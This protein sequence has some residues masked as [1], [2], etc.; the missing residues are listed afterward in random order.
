MSK[1]HLAIVIRT[2]V[3]A[4]LSIGWG[5]LGMCG[6]ERGV[7][8][9]V[10]ILA[11]DM[12]F[13]DAGCYG[14][15]IRTPNLDRLAS[16]GLRFT[17]FYNTARCW[18]S[19]A[20]ILTGY[21]AQ[22]VHRDA[23]PGLD[24]GA[25][26]KRP[27]W[28][29]LLPEL[30][31][32]LGYRSYHSGKWHMDGKVLA[33]GFDH[34]YSLNDHDRH[35][36]PRQH[37]LDDRP[38]PAVEPGSGYYST[39]A[40]AQHAIEMLA[41]HDAKH[42]GT[43]FFLYLAFTCPHF[44]VQAL[45]QDIAVYRER[46]RSGWDVLRQERYERMR[47]MGLVNCPLSALEPDYV[48]S[49]N[50]PEEQLRAEIG[51]GEVARAVAWTSLT[52]EQQQFQPV[53][54][55]IHAAMIHRMDI[56]VGRVVDQLRAMGTLENTVIFFL[57]DNGASA[58]QI[59]RGDRHDRTA[60]PGSAKTFLSIGPAWSS[61]ANTPF[62]LHKSWVHEGG[63]TTPLIVHWPQGISARG[64]MRHDPGHL[65]DLAPTIL[66]LA[67]GKWPETFA[68]KPVP[69]PPGKSLV[70][71]FAKDGV[72][73]HDYFWWYHIGNRAIR[74]GDWKLVAAANAPWELYDLR[75]DRSE[76]SDLATSHPETVRKLE[77]AWIRHTEEIRALAE[78]DHQ[79][80]QA[81]GKPQRKPG[82]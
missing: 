37:T 42:R 6:G 33:G 67:H 11:D 17:Q 44:P 77:Q 73:T 25:L 59:I 7:P 78:R 50:L 48:P 70:A 38:L 61:A 68:G 82:D 10:I 39:T 63:I 54:M 4:V 62:R 65:I 19:R 69:P 8:N 13:S 16:G 46:Y 58:E 72:V 34:S 75:T 18:P 29:R 36:N 55:A 49:W 12:G 57:S 60:P 2:A 79:S 27:D 64:E 20:S 14:G 74:V 3:L 31:R 28:A 41:E 1:A 80:T 52:A 35:F 24:G 5:N 22:Q 81:G 9:I 43:P 47:A 23:L 26:G 53:K 51:P 21:Y 30:L 66:E 32:P 15:E 56:E 71:A 76:S 40:I 45:P